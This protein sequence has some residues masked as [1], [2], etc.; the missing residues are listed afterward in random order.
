M[1]ASSVQGPVLHQLFRTA[2]TAELENGFSSCTSVRAISQMRTKL[3][4]PHRLAHRQE[5]CN[6]GASW[7]PV[8]AAYTELHA[9]HKDSSNSKRECLKVSRVWD[10]A[11]SEAST[12][13]PTSAIKDQSP[14]LQ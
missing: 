12:G 5:S 3:K 1:P 2:S 11:R 7:F 14:R 8:V 6:H 10:C 4:K 13:H 9:A